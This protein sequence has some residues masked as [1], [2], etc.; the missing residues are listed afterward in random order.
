[1]LT[2]IPLKMLKLV[3]GI[4]LISGYDIAGVIQI[5]EMGGRGRTRKKEPNNLIFGG[6]PNGIRPP[7]TMTPNGTEDTN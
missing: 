1:M 3:V 5:D 4:T 6:K 2:A 7:D